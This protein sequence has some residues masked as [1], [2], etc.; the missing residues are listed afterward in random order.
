MDAQL[1]RRKSALMDILMGLIAMIASSAGGAELL[2]VTW[3]TRNASP[4][5][6]LDPSASQLLPAFRFAMAALPEA[7]IVTLA[8]SQPALLGLTQAQASVLQPLTARRYQLMA[9]STLYAQA[10]QLY[11]QLICL[12]AYPPDNTIARF[13]SSAVLRFLSG[14]AEPFVVSGDFHRRMERVR[15]LC[16]KVEEVTI[17]KADHF[18]LLTHQEETLKV[19]RRWLGRGGK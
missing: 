11:S 16:P 9:G 17:P 19:L 2:Q 1:I 4:P 12:A 15:R 14:G 10:P 6:R 8:L 18:F 13:T 3:P 7:S 5:L